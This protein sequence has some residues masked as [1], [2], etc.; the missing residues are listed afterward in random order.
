MPH[1]FFIMFNASLT[2]KIF[3]IP[4]SPC[5]GIWKQAINTQNSSPEDIYL[6]GTEPEV[7]ERKMFILKEKSLVVLIAP[8]DTDK[9]KLDKNNKNR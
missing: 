6:P 8:L 2:P 9:N 5:S 1:N 3:Q 7:K 4:I